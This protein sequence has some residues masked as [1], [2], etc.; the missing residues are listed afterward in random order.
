MTQILTQD[1]S[2]PSHHLTSIS[3]TAYQL[4]PYPHPTHT[5]TT[6]A[7][8]RTP[9]PR[10]LDQDENV[11]PHPA[12]SAVPTSMVALN[13]RLLAIARNKARPAVS[14]Q[15]LL[16][17][18]VAPVELPLTP[19]SSRDAGAR[20]APQP[21]GKLT[22]PSPARPARSL[23][24]GSGPRTSSSSMES[25]ASGP[26]QQRS[27]SP[28]RTAAPGTPA[29]S[30]TGTAGSS[31]VAV[32]K[33]PRAA[34]S[35]ALDRVRSST[36]SGSVQASQ[37]GDSPNPRN[38]KTF[39]A[40]PRTP[41]RGTPSR[42]IASG[43]E[44]TPLAAEE[45][46][47]ADEDTSID[48]SL[49]ASIVRERERL[50]SPVRGAAATGKAARKS[51]MSPSDDG[52]TSFLREVRE[53]G[54]DH[55]NLASPVRVRIVAP[56]KL[57]V[58]APRASSVVPRKSA[59]KA[60]VS[61][62]RAGSAKPRARPTP[63]PQAVNRISE[64]AVAPSSPSDDPLL[65]VGNSSRYGRRTPRAKREVGVGSD[66]AQEQWEAELDNEVREALHSSRSADD[67]FASH[68]RAMAQAQQANDHASLEQSYAGDAYA[69]EDGYDGFGDDAGEAPSPLP[70]PSPLPEERSQS[71]SR[72]LEEEQEPSMQQHDG[73]A[74][75]SID[76]AGWVSGPAKAMDD[77]DEEEEDE[78]ATADASQS[79]AQESSGDMSASAQ[80][81][82]ERSAELDAED[83]SMHSP[84][85]EYDEQD[86][87]ASA[88]QSASHDPEPT[89]DESQ[90]QSSSNVV[91]QQEY[92]ESLRAYESDSDDGGEPEIVSIVRAGE[93]VEQSE[94]ELR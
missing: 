89:F 4:T 93:V 8:A 40:A 66:A 71:H 54:W 23:V 87:S 60:R 38:R 46:G 61:Q 69:D 59:P 10:R 24:L 90:E 91:E 12:P 92:D 19:P 16:A 2:L 72:S 30:R 7:M 27:S 29:R 37:Q 25:C 82:S 58:R 70:S 42:R 26:G 83:V 6:T 65:I 45:E 33:R 67:T 53:K 75:M 18:P 79:F 63:P 88:Q 5:H 84:R 3:T 73:A 80:L 94:A 14:S 64:R 76:D 86:Q 51:R 22:S 52:D 28:S 36:S 62:L 77:D 35:P 47:E 81:E 85:V 41:P 1:P 55:M 74:D 21:D 17:P 68:P 20:V 34:A 13:A 15:S 44:W 39:R 9:L 56:A 43:A 31:G 32:S 57:P 49:D 11:N 78:A 50:A 48:A